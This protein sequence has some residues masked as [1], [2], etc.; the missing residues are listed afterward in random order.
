MELSLRL[1]AERGD[2][3]IARQ[4]PRE[5]QRGDQ[6]V[7][8]AVDAV[9][10]A[11]VL[12][13]HS[14]RR[15]VEGGRAVDLPNRSR[16]DRLE[17]EGG[18]ARAPVRLPLRLEDAQKLRLGHRVPVRA[19]RGDRLGE[20]GRQELVAF[21]REQLTELHRGAAQVREP[22]REPAPVRRREQ[23]APGRVLASANQPARVLERAAERELAR[24]PAD[25]AHALER[26]ARHA[27]ASA[28]RGVAHCASRVSFARRRHSIGASRS[29][30]RVHGSRCGERRLRSK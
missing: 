26:A 7:D 17:L 13:L 27:R 2:I 16:G 1:G 12:Q 9:C 30:A 19:Q 15:P 20:L 28:R 5:P 10:D 25:A 4:E 29:P 24:E 11:G 21:E 22:L 6:A 23:R 18:D 3:D 8:I 14:E